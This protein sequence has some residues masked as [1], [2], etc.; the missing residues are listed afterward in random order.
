MTI[1]SE[2][3][4][5]NIHPSSHIHTPSKPDE[6]FKTRIRSK[7]SSN[8]TPTSNSVLSKSNSS[9]TRSK[10]LNIFAVSPIPPTTKPSS[11][12]PPTPARSRSNSQAAFTEKQEVRYTNDLKYEVELPPM[13]QLVS[14]DIDEQ[15]RYLALKE[16][17]IVEIKDRMQS[18]TNKLA[19]HEHELQRLRKVIQRSLYA[20]VNGT[21][22]RQKATVRL[23]QNSQNEDQS[24]KLSVSEQQQHV[25]KQPPQNNNQTGILNGLSRPLSMLQQLDTII[26]D[27]FEKSLIPEKETQAHRDNTLHTHRSRL[28]QDSISTTGSNSPLKLR[29]TRLSVGPYE[30]APDLWDIKQ[31]TDDMLQTVTDSIRSLFTDVKTNVLSSLTEEFGVGELPKQSHATLGHSQNSADSLQKLQKENKNLK[32]FSF[33]NTVETEESIPEG[34]DFDDDDFLEPIMSDD[35]DGIDDK[36]D[37]SIYKV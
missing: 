30:A 5:F 3:P 18:L 6:Q 34:D 23:R 25:T 33:I 31:S 17:C 10:G 26:Q 21:S 24:R 9:S 35:D 19:T 16:M 4:E 22:H 2:H 13:D 28:S 20:E 36:L 8:S 37:L 1:A 29:S 12:S 14:M 32:R 27:G 7:S 15:L 11:I